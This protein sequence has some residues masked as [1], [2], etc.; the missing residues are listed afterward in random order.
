MFLI[1]M[2]VWNTSL[3][4]AFTLLSY[5]GVMLLKKKNVCTY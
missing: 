5:C 3:L 1:K 4:T 2:S